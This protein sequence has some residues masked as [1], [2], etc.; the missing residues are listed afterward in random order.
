[1]RINLDLR[2]A[3]WGGGISNYVRNIALQI[4]TS[5]KDL[6]LVG[7]YNSTRGR[8][9]SDYNWFNGKIKSSC[10]PDR[11]A[12]NNQ[13]CL[14]ISYETM[15]T[16]NADINLFLTYRLP[17]MDFKKP[18]V[19]TIHDIILLKT[20]CEAQKVLKEHKAILDYTIKKSKYL[21][22]VSENSKK[23][24]CET[25]NFNPDNIF[26]VHN[27]IHVSEF[28]Q[29]ESPDREKE[30]RDKY[31][32]PSKF[33]LNLG[34]YRIHKNIERLIQAYSQTE[35]EF[36]KEVKLVITNQHPDLVKEVGK[37]GIEEDVLFTTYIAEEDKP[38]LYNM[39]L[40]VYYAS[41]YEGWGV[42]I[43]EAQASRTPVITSKIASMPE[44]SNGYAVL[45]DPFNVD[46]IK[47]AI[48][49]L[50]EDKCLRDDLILNGYNNAVR[51]TWDNSGKELYSA[52]KQMTF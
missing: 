33:I 19:S 29:K 11:I 3:L 41:L 49:M 35:K 16:S 48:M 28:T 51:Y 21:I 23:D 14:P 8:K 7:C 52:L 31:K 25:F 10:I 43:I 34:A 9:K 40:M 45:V 37:W 18:V 15:M 36:R 50:A 47:R 44:A 2:N 4:S 42:P 22:T 26:V 32:I 12:Y 24:I 30:V 39:A 38:I 1:M 5:Y 17:F 46:E 27:G 13:F 6:E 20:G